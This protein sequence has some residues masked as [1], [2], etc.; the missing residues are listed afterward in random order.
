[1]PDDAAALFAAAGVEAKVEHARQNGAIRIPTSRKHHGAK[2]AEGEK[3]GRAMLFSGTYMAYRNRR[4]HREIKDS[5]FAAQLSEFL[6]V[7]H[8]FRL[9]TESVEA[10]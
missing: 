6:L 10:P 7:N 2:I 1:V 8:L 5:H 4:A 9:E 3:S